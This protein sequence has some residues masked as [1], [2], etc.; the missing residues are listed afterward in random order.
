MGPP[1]LSP[2]LPLPLSPPLSPADGTIDALRHSKEPEGRSNRFLERSWGMNPLPSKSPLD[3]ILLPLRAS[4]ISREFLG[5]TLPDIP[6]LILGRPPCEKFGALARFLA[7][8]FPGR[9]PDRPMRIIWRLSGWSLSDGSEFAS[10]SVHRLGLY[11]TEVSPPGGG[12]VNSSDLPQKN[13]FSEKGVNHCYWRRI[14][15]R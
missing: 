7:D 6:D 12:G 11:M 9:H 1:L 4:G 5:G 14:R 2:P 3:G 15:R 8:R 10:N 13:K